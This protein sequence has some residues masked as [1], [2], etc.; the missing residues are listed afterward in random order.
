M[1]DPESKAL[2]TSFTYSE[3][4]AFTIEFP[5]GATRI[6]FDAPNQ[7]FAARTAEGIAKS[8]PSPVE[9]A[10]SPD[11]TKSLRLQMH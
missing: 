6:P 1:P 11:V 9:S 8:V 7:V 10:I 3:K 2:G 5:E 4:P